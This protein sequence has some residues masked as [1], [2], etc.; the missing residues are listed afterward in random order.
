MQ[1]MP[2]IDTKKNLISSVELKQLILTFIEYR[3]LSRQFLS[4]TKHIKSL[5]IDRQAGS[6]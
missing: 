4:A 1:T 5:L 3:Y 6:V 2:I